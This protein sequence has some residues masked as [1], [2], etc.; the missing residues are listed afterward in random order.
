MADNV[1]GWHMIVDC[2]QCDI[3]SVTDGDNIYNFVKDLV[4]RIDMKAYGEPVIEHF[5]THDIDK[6]GYSL[7]Q[8]IETSNITAHFVD[9]NGDAYVDVFSCKPF[10]EIDVL[11]CIQDYF[12]PKHMSSRV[13]NRAAYEVE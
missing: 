7:V 6:A 1:W 10:Q 8:L 12:N 2:S 3:P 13:F 4:V 5:A 11:N 9:K